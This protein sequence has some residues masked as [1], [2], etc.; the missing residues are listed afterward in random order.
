MVLWLEPE[1]RCQLETEVLERYHLSL[2][3]RGV[4]DYR[5]EQL[6]E[7]YK[8]TITQSIYVPSQ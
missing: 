1:L 6:L 3:S 4:R 2:L 8:L 7:D 5:W